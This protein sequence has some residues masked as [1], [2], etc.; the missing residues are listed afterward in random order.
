MK[1]KWKFR[2]SGFKHNLGCVWPFS[3]VWIIVMVLTTPIIAIGMMV[4]G[5]VPESSHGDVWYFLLTRMP[6]IGL[7]AVVLAI[8]TTNRVAGPLINLRRTFEDVKDGNLD[9]RLKFRSNER[10]L[11]EVETAFNEMMEALRDGIDA[12]QDSEI[13]GTV[14][15]QPEDGTAT[16][17]VA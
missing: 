17:R 8:F 15:E 13:A 11:H 16:D 10:H 4:G 2:G 6:L 5:V 12:H 14:G 1:N 7:A 9:R 3:G